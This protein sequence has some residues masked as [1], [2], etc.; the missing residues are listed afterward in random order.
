[1]L[2]ERRG[3]KMNFNF[4]MWLLFGLFVLNGCVYKT[5]GPLTECHFYRGEIYQLERIDDQLNVF[6]Q[7]KSLESSMRSTKKIVFLNP[8]LGPEMSLKIGTSVCFQLDKKGKPW[9]V[10][11]DVREPLLPMTHLPVL[12]AFRVK[13]PPILDGNLNDSCWG[14]CAP[15]TLFED[16]EGKNKEDTSHLILP[17]YVKACYD[18]NYLYLGATLIEPHISASLTTRDTFIFY[19]ND[20]EVFLDPDGDHHNYAE[21]EVNA[22]N[23]VWD[24]FLTKPYK[25]QG[26]AITAWDIHG[27][28]TAVKIDGTLNVANDLDTAWFVEM[29][30]PFKALGACGVT[31]MPKLN[32]NWRVNFSRVEWAYTRHLNS[33][34]KIPH[35]SESNWVWSPTGIIAIHHPERWGYLVFVEHTPTQNGPTDPIVNELNDIYYAQRAHYQNARH[36]C[37]DIKRLTTLFLLPKEIEQR[38]Y[39]LEQTPQGWRA[40]FKDLK[41]K[42]V[43]RMIQDGRLE[44]SEK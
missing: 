36:Y 27:L 26:V 39:L 12:S 43:Y 42:R 10:F 15:S 41:N 4:F 40:S 1:M 31:S 32:S 30:I 16:I 5:V 7:Y 37:T 33:Y 44:I 25:D 6:V 22:L 38:D 3:F 17:T 18:Q 11:W 20:F 14:K 35:S 19:D 2:N 9:D 21:I 24:L 29:A 23:T 13:T 28:K 8:T 34:K